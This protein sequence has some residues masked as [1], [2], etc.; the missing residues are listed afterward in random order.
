M[1]HPTSKARFARGFWA[2]TA[3][4]NRFDAIR[5]QL[6]AL[7]AAVTGVFLTLVD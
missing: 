6:L 4:D 2:D 1:P 3:S 5:R 7:S